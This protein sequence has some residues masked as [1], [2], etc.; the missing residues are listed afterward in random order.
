MV[1]SKEER[2]AKVKEYQLRPEIKAKRREHAQ[3]PEERKRRRAR[4][5]S[6]EGRKR[7]RA[8][9]SRPETIA[10]RKDDREI[11]RL[12]VLQYY[13]KVHSNSD[14]LCCRCCGLNSHTY[15]L[16]ID[17]ILGSKQMDSIPEVVK[18]GYSSKMRSMNLTNWI[19]ANNYL[20]DLQTE[21]FQVLCHNCNLAKGYSE[22][23]KCPL[24][25]M[26]H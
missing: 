12:K 18:L 20:K 16:S 14:V 21:Y 5:Q 22:D 26:S 23:N 24:E 3:S 19:I 9:E 17:H 6:P 8:I 7:R 13:S 2:K 11:S 15:F 1:Q 25:N 4:D 10:K